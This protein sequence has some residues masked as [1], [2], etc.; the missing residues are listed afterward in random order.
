MWPYKSL[1]SYAVL[2]ESLIWG[3]RAGKRLFGTH[4][5]SGSSGADMTTGFANRLALAFGSVLQPGELIGIGHDGS[6]YARLIAGAMESGLH[7]SGVHTVSFGVSTSAVSRFA[8]S[9]LECRGGLH[10]RRLSDEEPDRLAI[11]FLDE[12]GLPLSPDA[13]RKI[14]NAY[15]QEDMRR[16]PAHRL[17]RRK[18]GQRAIELYGD[19][20][21]AALERH[22]VRDLGYVVVLEHGG[23]PFDALLSRIFEA[24]GCRAIRL[25]R[26]PSARSAAAADLAD[27]VR[28]NGADLGVRLDAGGQV[29]LL[30]TDRGEPVGED[31]LFVLQTMAQL[32]QQ[33]SPLAVPVNA[34][35]IDWLLGMAVSGGVVRT[36]ADPRALMESSRH[37]GLHIHF[38]GLYSLVMTLQLMAVQGKRL[39][40]LIEAVPAFALFKK[41]VECPWNEKGKVMRFLMEETKGKKVELIDGI[42]VFHDEGWTLI[43][44]DREEPMFQV[45]ANADSPQMAEE[46]A[47]RYAQK[48]M[49]FRER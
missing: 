42:K 8:T 20:L 12:E 9:Q 4:G 2:S 46:L 43:L 7:A 22:A 26:A 11:E 30:V 28:C 23:E 14:E 38:D 36:K 10:V 37:E 44:P 25:Q 6:P 33:D 21:L 49:H 40:Q 31:M 5:V 35:D 13:E 18:P 34:P 47:V 1:E 29:A 17:G 24:L 48:I 32:E 19:R 27:C 45:F 3:D 15:I 16:M 39:S 41:Q